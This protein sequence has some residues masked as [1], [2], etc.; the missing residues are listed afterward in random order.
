SFFNQ[1]PLMAADSRM[2]SVKAPPQ[3]ITAEAWLRI[4]ADIE[5]RTYSIR[6]T[7]EQ[8]GHLVADNPAQH[9]EALFDSAGVELIPAAI[10]CIAAPKAS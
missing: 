9:L 3:G 5:Q 6:T 4:T 10:R 2:A 1:L 7:G 8:H